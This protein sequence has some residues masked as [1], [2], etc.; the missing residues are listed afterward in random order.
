MSAALYGI[1]KN[2]S[3]TYRAPQLNLTQDGCCLIYLPWRD[4]RLS[5]PGWLV[6]YQDGLPVHPSSNH[7]IVTWP[8][9]E[10]TTSWS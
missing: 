9:V 3:Q 4:G 10:P 2:Q 5:W 1:Y 8:G 6:I 7:V